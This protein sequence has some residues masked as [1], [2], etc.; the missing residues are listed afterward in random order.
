MDQGNIIQYLKPKEN[1]EV[2]RIELLTDVVDGLSYVHSHH[3]VHGNLKGANIY[4]KN[5]RACIAGFSVSTIAKVGPWTGAGGPSTDSLP[6]FTSGGSLRW[7][8]PELLD[9]SRLEDRDPRPT[10]ES[11]CFALGMVIYEVLCGHVPYDGW[12]TERINDAIL[13]G[14]RPYKPDAA[15][16]IGLVDELWELLQ[17]C[18]EEKREGRPDLR[19]VRACLKEVVPLWH[20]RKELSSTMVDDTDSTYSRSDYSALPSPSPSPATVALPSSP[21]L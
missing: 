19:A 17:R 15:A 3:V 14:V 6:S 10:K 16:K 4:I 9:P 18:W 11:D 7:M 5:F 12:E 2:N 21:P 20:V 13:Q 1:L 8:S